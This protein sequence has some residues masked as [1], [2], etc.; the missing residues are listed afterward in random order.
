M[1]ETPLSMYASAFLPRMSALTHACRQVG[2]AAL[3]ANGT[4]SKG[5]A[6][7]LGST[8]VQRLL[9]CEIEAATQDLV[10]SVGGNLI[11]N[12]M[13][14]KVVAHISPRLGTTVLF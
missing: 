9:G 12:P 1:L 14:A 7:A 4:L 8:N 3:E 2:W 5:D 13:A 6:I 10:A 11:E